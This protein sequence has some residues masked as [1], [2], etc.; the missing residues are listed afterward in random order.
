M[1]C[2]MLVAIGKLPLGRLL[3]DFKLVAQ[4]QNERH[5]HRDD[6]DHIQGDGWGMV[7]G[8]AGGFECYK[9]V[10]PC[11]T[12]PRFI[13]LHKADLDFIM[14]HARKASPGMAVKYEFT[15]PFEEDGWRFC[16]NGTIHDFEVKERSDAQQL[17]ALILENARQCP[18][19]TEA[20]R[21]TVK[22][23]KDYSALNFMLFKDDRV[24]VLNMYGGRGEKTP[25]YFTIKYL[26]ADDYTVI[27]SERLPSCGTEWQEMRN[28][29]LL[30]LAIPDRQIEIC[31]IRS[32]PG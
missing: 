6:P 9:N 23:L 17:F 16:H 31:K 19:T 10:M 14:L 1:A 11:W 30:T 22:S 29:T 27:S 15:H 28:A 12:D 32:A 13:D 20:I 21:R 8:K 5:E 4:N 25:N 7:T 3:G 2:R 24:Y 18:N 26:Q